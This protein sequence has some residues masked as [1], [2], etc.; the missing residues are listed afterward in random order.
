MFWVFRFRPSRRRSDFREVNNSIPNSTFVLSFALSHLKTGITLAFRNGS[1]RY[2]RRV[3]KMSGVPVE[4]M[5]G[6][7][8]PPKAPKGPRNN[9]CINR[10]HLQF[11]IISRLILCEQGGGRVR[12]GRV[13]KNPAPTRLPPEVGSISSRGLEQVLTHFNL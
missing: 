13:S 6:P 12:R 5:I 11:S 2:F 7:Q 3:A 4:A 9:V 1:I 10:A 8:R